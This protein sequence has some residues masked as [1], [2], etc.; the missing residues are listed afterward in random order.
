MRAAPGDLLIYPHAHRISRNRQSNRDPGVFERSGP[1]GCSRCR[2]HQSPAY[3][4]AFKLSWVIRKSVISTSEGKRPM[5]FGTSK[6]TLI[7][8]LF[9]IP[10]RYKR[11][12]EIK[13]FSSKRG[14]CRRKESV[15]ISDM[16]FLAMAMHSSSISRTRGLMGAANF[17][18]RVMLMDKN[19]EVLDSAIV[20]SSSNA[21]PL[22]ILQRK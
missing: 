16:H 11:K 4:L 5:R 17:L 8:L 13:P 12:A 22:F 2:E 15:R 21:A 18:A 20:Q 10:S 14:G 6:F 3:L 7:V 1:K 19:R 9:A